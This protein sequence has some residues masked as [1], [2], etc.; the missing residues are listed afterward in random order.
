M[1]G[2]LRL[3]RGSGTG[4]SGRAAKFPAPVNECRGCDVEECDGREQ[5]VRVESFDGA[6]TRLYAASY[7]VAF[8]L[9]GERAEAEDVAQE[10]LAR[11]FVRWSRVEPFA[12]AWACRVAFNLAIDRTRRRRPL[13]G[14]AVPDQ[15]T[16]DGHAEERMDLQRALRTLPRRQREVVALRYLADQSEAVVA[17][18]LGI[19]VGSAKTH[20]SR[21]LT[22]LRAQLGAMRVGS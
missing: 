18:A 7:A 16:V 1:L 22:A 11:T 17:A 19:S 20:A 3:S 2:V 5:A 13:S 21:G 9:L 6:F 8:R 4:A 10:A 12:T 15:A 14:S